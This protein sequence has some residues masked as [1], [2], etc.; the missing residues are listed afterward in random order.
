[1]FQAQLI[2]GSYS[3]ACQIVSDCAP[4]QK[5]QYFVSASAKQDLRKLKKITKRKRQVFQK[6]ATGSVVPG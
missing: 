1:M 4:D 2:Q 5:K 3:V 6:T